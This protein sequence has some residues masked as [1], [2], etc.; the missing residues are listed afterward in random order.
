VPQER[1]NKKLTPQERAELNQQL[2]AFRKTG[3]MYLSDED[4][5]MD[6]SKVD[7]P[8]YDNKVPRGNEGR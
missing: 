8:A 7:D 5:D 3:E 1:K 4:L 2:D 6:F